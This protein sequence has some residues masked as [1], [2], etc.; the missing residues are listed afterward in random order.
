[1]ALSDAGS[2]VKSTSFLSQATNGKHNKV[3]F[4]RYFLLK[5]R[6]KSL[7]SRQQFMAFPQIAQHV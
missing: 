7:L 2:N 5:G 1:M 6:G 4:S 3:F